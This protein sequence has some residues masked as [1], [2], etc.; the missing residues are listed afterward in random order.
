MKEELDVLV[1]YKGNHTND[2]KCV[3]FFIY[4]DSAS[5]TIKTFTFWN[6]LAF[7]IVSGFVRKISMT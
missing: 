4:C 1:L 7:D 2:V 5:D 6:I 3:W